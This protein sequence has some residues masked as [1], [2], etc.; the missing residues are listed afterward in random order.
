MHLLFFFLFL[1]FIPFASL[2]IC[3]CSSDSCNFPNCTTDGL[4]VVMFVGLKFDLIIQQCVSPNFIPS[5]C[6]FS[7]DNRYCCRTEFCNNSTILH[8]LFVTTDLPTNTSTYLSRSTS[9][10]LPSTQPSYGLTL[11]VASL[12]AVFFI[13][14]S[15]VLICL[16]FLPIF[17]WWRSQHLTGVRLEYKKHQCLEEM[18]SESDSTY[19]SC[20]GSGA[21]MAQLS[22]VT[23]A[24]QA[25][26]LLFCV[27]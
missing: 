2:L 3:H 9:Q 11:L 20:S 5:T 16:I 10:S 24:R 21:G 1:V 17:I 15:L 14:L 25:S 4:C 23:I 7:S 26:Y 27:F 19:G 18:T 13:I 8:Q 6:T 12:V 22:Q